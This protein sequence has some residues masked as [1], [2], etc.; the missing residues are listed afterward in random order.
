MKDGKPIEPSDNLEIKQLPDGTCLLNISDA[1]PSDR[2][3]YSV[4]LESP[5]GKAES[6]SA[7][8]V[9]GKH[10]KPEFV[11][12][13]EAPSSVPSGKHLKLTAKVND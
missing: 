13:L 7:I 4:I 9:H 8:E 11:K 5:E 10:R 3:S 12:D 2:G 1:K 6:S